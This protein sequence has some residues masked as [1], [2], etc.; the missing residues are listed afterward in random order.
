MVAIKGVL[1]ATGPFF[2][3]GLRIL[4]AGMLVLLVAWLQGRSH[5]QGWRGWLWVGGFALV[6]GTLFQGFLAQGL[7]RT[8]AGLGSVLIDSQP[9]AVALLS[10]WLFGEI[11]GVWGWLGLGLG[12]A[13]IACIGIPIDALAAFDDIATSPGHWAVGLF[14]SGTGLMLLAA[15][16]MALGTV[17]IRYVARYCDVV[18]ASGWHMLLGGV[19]L[20][21]LSGL[22][23]TEPW[24]HLSAPD[25]LAIAYTSVFGGAVAYGLF[26][27]FA[28]TRNLTSFSALTFLTPVFALVLGY[29]SLGE[30]LTGQQW[31][32]VAVTLASVYLINQRREL[33]SRSERSPGASQVLSEPTRI[34]SSSSGRSQP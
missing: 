11:V 33:Q 24:Q 1:P 21:L 29:I 25:W 19:P 2:I 30:T 5:P 18:S 22:T 6:D 8:G 27:Y 17:A 13:G 14:D 9:L 34:E 7:V 15:V 3:A 31:V 20:L 16:S 4:P 23:E 26:F 28:S 32:G 10:R 12:V